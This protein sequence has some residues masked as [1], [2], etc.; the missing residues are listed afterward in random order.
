MNSHHKTE[1]TEPVRYVPLDVSK[2]R[3]DYG[4]EPGRSAAV[5]NTTEGIALLLQRLAGCPHARVVC[6]S[7]GGYERTLLRAFAQAVR[8][9]YAARQAGLM[10]RRQAAVATSPLTSFLA[11]GGG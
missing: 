9:G 2:R 11:G 10:S 6:E 4:W 5:A 1:S 8:A 3:L 7:T